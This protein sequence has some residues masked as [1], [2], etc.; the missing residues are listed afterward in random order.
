MNIG[1]HTTHRRRRLLGTTDTG[2]VSNARSTLPF[3]EREVMPAWLVCAY[4]TRLCLILI[5]VDKTSVG[6]WEA[7]ILNC[8]LTV[9]GS[10]AP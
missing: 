8:K 6:V 2:R 4:H 9:G 5:W 7:D 10:C 1:T 3:V